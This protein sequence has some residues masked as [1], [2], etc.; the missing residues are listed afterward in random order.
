[1]KGADLVSSARRNHSDE[2][3]ELGVAGERIE[4]LSSMS[5]K[6]RSDEAMADWRVR[7]AS[8]SGKPAVWTGCSAPRT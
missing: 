1:M 4:S 3:G 5:A 8:D 2:A 7:S 6:M